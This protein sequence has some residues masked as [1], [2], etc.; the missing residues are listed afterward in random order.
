VSHPIVKLVAALAL[1]ATAPLPTL[2][3][4]LGVA[5]PPPVSEAPPVVAP[6][7]VVAVA[8]PPVAVAPCPVVRRCGY[9][10]CGWRPVCGPIVRPYWAGAA[11][12][13]YGPYGYRRFGMGYGPAYGRGYWG[14]HPGWGHY[15]W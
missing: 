11:W 3:A 6:P 10:G 14:G 1:L 13:Y 8:P 5:P 4:D 2:A 9:W 12:R 7:P 15:R